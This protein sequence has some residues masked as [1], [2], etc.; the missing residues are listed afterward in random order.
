M[1][2]RHDR[3]RCGF[4]RRLLSSGERPT[5]IIYDNDVMP[6]AGLGVAHE[7]GL[8]VPRDVSIVAWDDSPLCQLVHPALTALSRDIPGYG[9]LAARQ[10]LS[11]IARKTVESVQDKAPHLVTRGSTAAPPRDRVHEVESTR[12]DG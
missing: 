2:I 7:M 12:S 4:A 3:E 5:A 1:R 10:S 6:I 8:S 9:A 11:V